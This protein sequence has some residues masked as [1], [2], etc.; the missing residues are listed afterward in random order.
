MKAFDK[1]ERV[2]G[3][4][5]SW[6]ISDSGDD[7]PSRPAR[8]RPSTSPIVRPPES[9]Q[10]EKP[11]GQPQAVKPQE[12][13]QGKPPVD[14]DSLIH[15]IHFDESDPDQPV[16]SA[17]HDEVVY[18]GSAGGSPQR[19]AS[20]M[21]EMKQSLHTQEAML[22]DAKAAAAKRAQLVKIM[23]KEEA[24]RYFAFKEAESWKTV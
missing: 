6:Y 24:E 9:P 21:V 23:G 8:F 18:V 12:P 20:A 15:E 3:R 11:Q 22:A 7:Q 17:G 2:K 1:A 10:A 4:A 13:S 16:D 5:G 14:W 19:M